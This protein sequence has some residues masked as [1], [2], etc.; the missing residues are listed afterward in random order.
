M[1]LGT[2]VFDYTVE[3][4]RFGDCEVNVR[5]HGEYEVPER[6]TGI[7]GGWS[8]NYITFADGVEWDRLEIERELG[9]D[10]LNRMDL[11]AFEAARDEWE[12]ALS[13][14]RDL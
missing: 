6:E 4:R 12:S 1:S 3:P 7:P 9:A 8:V 10:E 11:A 13:I 14:R 5:A 2:V